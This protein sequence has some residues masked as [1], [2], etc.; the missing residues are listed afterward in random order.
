MGSRGLFLSHWTLTFNPDME[1]STT[2]VWI[3]LPCLPLLFWGEDCFKS[4]G[5]K[6]GR[7][8]T[9]PAPKGNIFTCAR[10]CVDM[11][12]AKGLPE[13]IQLNLEGWSH[14]QALDYEQVPFKCNFFHDYGHFVKSFPKAQKSQPSLN[15]DNQGF[16]QVSR[17]HKKQQPRGSQPDHRPQGHH[18]PPKI[19]M[20]LWNP[21]RKKKRT[22]LRMMMILKK[23]AQRAK[24]SHLQ[25]NKRILKIQA[26][27]TGLKFWNLRKRN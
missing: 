7:Y 23:T 16:K 20:K 2:P 10:I 4:I 15:I 9:H 12:F 21:K 3:R 17:K 19:D 22:Q 25:K 24:Q 1:I 26:P 8:I 27:I 11:D 5:N 6:L 14:L 13:A 18:I